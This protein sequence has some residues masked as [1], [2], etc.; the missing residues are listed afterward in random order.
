MTHMPAKARKRAHPGTCM[1][2]LAEVLQVTLRSDFSLEDAYHTTVSLSKPAPDETCPVTLEKMSEYDLDFLPNV[3]FRKGCPEYRK[4]TM[5]CGH[6]F[7]AMALLY[8]FRKNSLSCP[9]CRKGTN[10]KLHHA[11]IP[12]HF[13]ASLLHKLA[14]DEAQER[15]EQ[16]RTDFAAALSFFSDDVSSTSL[17]LRELLSNVDL[18][19][20]FYSGD[21]LVPCSIHRYSMVSSS[22][23]EL[24]DFRLS[25]LLTHQCARQLRCNMRQLFEPSNMVFVL[26][27]RDLHGHVV[28]LDRGQI[29][30][31]LLMSRQE[32]QLIEWDKQVETLEGGSTLC[33]SFLQGAGNN[34]PEIESLAWTIPMA[35]AR[36]A[37]LDSALM[38]SR[39]VVEGVPMTTVVLG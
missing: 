29:H 3:T 13:R 14:Q 32:N 25:F 4:L 30:S 27:A 21:D 19:L 8:H 1:T 36:L 2:P 26:S 38:S 17:V 20:Y 34:P 33:V 11:C 28:Q 23:S 39:E 12:F 22:F 5:Q 6:S 35:T 37:V 15:E 9:M 31:S 10:Q 16:E 24:T 7:S 18:I